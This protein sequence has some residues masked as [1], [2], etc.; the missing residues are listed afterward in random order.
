MKPKLILCLALVLSGGL[1]GCAKNPKNTVMAGNEIANYYH[2]DVEKPS[3]QDRVKLAHDFP[4]LTPRNQ[5]VVLTFLW[6]KARCP[7]FADALLPLAKPPKQPEQENEDTLCDE[8]FIRLLDL[9]PEA[10][11]PII[12]EDLRRPNPL[13]SLCV[14][15]ALPD[16]E[17]PELDD[18]LLAHLNRQADLE[19]IPALI[20]RYATARILPQ[21]IAFYGTS[22]TGWMCSLQ[23]AI[24]RYW[25]KHDRPAALQAI[26]KAVNF[27][28][29]T[30]C[31]KTVL[32]ETLHDSFDADAEKLARKFINDSDPD[33]AADARN[34]LAQHD[35]MP[36]QP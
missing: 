17:L 28:K 8:V 30:G 12:L 33:V 18:V 19:K 1:F 24:L 4:K 23:T 29:S 5:Y 21:V 22:E 15:Q 32:G 36:H 14:L 13:F 9:K 6:P 11:R 3:P 35:S 25:L 16:K 31:F 2:L 26:E 34:L 10:M 27:R 7:E 20:E